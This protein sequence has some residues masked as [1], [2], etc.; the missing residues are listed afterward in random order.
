MPY[1]MLYTTTHTV[2]YIVYTILNYT[3]HILLS[4]YTGKPATS[5]P[6]PGSAD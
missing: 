3:T 6:H 2:Y 5:R 4:I 1:T